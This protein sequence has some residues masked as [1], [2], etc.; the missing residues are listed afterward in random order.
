VVVVDAVAAAT[1]AAIVATANQARFS[2]LNAAEP[3]R[4]S[5]HRSRWW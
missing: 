2:S 5:A 4:A 1:A 3:L